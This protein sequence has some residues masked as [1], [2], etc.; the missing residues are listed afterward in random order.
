MQPLTSLTAT[1]LTAAI[2]DRR[3]SAIE[4][5]DA[6]LAQIARHNP[7][8]NAVVT[9]DEEGARRRAREADEAL[10]R[11]ELWGPLH[12]LPM[13]LKDGHST[14]GMRT[15][16][17]YPPLA[18]YVPTEDGT[19][20]ARLKT[21]G[22]III[23]KTNVSQQLMDIQSNNPIFGR[24]DNPWNLERTSGG[25]SGG[26]C[27]ALA[28]GMTPLE[29]GSDFG[30]SIRIPSAFCGVFGLKTTEHRVSMAGH[31]PSLPGVPRT[32]RIMWSIGPLA[33]SVE[34]LALAH[35]IIAGPDPRDPDVPPITPPEQ[36][37]LK[38]AG[39]RVAWA[40]TFPG[41]PVAGAISGAIEGLASELD[42][43]GARVEEVL[44]DVDFGQ[45][46]RTRTVLSRAARVTFAPTEEEPIETLPDYFAAQDRRDDFI[47]TWELFF[48]DW[49]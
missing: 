45:L 10:A 23:G 43:L 39:L 16:A 29:V 7:T 40:R 22:A 42:G 11:G 36:P 4:A 14:A 27:A 31:I 12:G 17:G 9:L 3:I 49:D 44:P 24:T 30:G 37:P 15:T 2:R 25:S 47:R 33:R 32:N 21:A 48:D 46:A 8:L 1:E 28:T 20:A 18:S 38:L 19:V 41:V 35:R 13:T 6:H 5:L 26:A 34:D